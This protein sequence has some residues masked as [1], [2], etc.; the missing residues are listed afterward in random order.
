M[1]KQIRHALKV[2]PIANEIKT[3]CIAL[4]PYR[5]LTTLTASL[6]F[7]HPE[8]QVLNHGS[9]FILPNSD[10]NFLVNCSEEAFSAFT[11]FAVQLSSGGSRGRR[12]GSITYSHAFDDARLSDSYQLRF[13]DSIVKER[14]ACLFWKESCRVTA[15]IR[16]HHIDF[17]NL[18][19]NYKKLRFLMPI[20]NPM[21]CAASNLKTGHAQFMIPGVTHPSY[22]AVL[23][24]VL[25]DILWF[26]SLQKKYPERLFYFFEHGFDRTTV[27]RLSSFLQLFPDVQW[28]N[29]V[30]SNYNIRHPYNYS[31][32]DVD[33]YR[34]TVL[35]RFRFNPEV[36]DQLLKFLM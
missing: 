33:Y 17:D 2:T 15:F 35:D 14:I 12:G 3:V 19:L 16:E 22:K 34:E 10:L 21:D 20:R 8:C 25:D 31:D 9:D 32:Q 13:N 28:V 23:L 24:N 1:S 36:R 5:N 11:E 30:M 26:T 18:F 27:D 6:L 7:L 4:G 29:D